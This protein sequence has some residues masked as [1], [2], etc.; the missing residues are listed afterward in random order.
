[1]S[2]RAK[3]ILLMSMLGFGVISVFNLVHAATDEAWVLSIPAA[4]AAAAAARSIYWWVLGRMM[5]DDV[6][7]PTDFG[8]DGPIEAIEVFWRP[9]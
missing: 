6:A 2:N 3:I 8:P 7:V 1:M 9:G 4:V 5:S